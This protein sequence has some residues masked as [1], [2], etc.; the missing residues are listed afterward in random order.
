MCLSRGL[1]RK[2]NSEDQQGMGETVDLK[3]CIT[4][5]RPLLGTA[6]GVPVDGCHASHQLGEHGQGARILPFASQHWVRVG[7]LPGVIAVIHPKGVGP[8]D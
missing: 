4:C 1:E 8:G 7:L 6:L 3:H 5:T 2:K